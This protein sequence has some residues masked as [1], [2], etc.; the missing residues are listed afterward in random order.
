MKAKRIVLSIVLV[1]SLALGISLG[2]SCLG[3]GDGGDVAA[4]VI[5]MLKMMP[6][7]ADDFMSIDME[8]L[9]TDD[10]FEEIY[11]DFVG[12]FSNL[13]EYMGI[14]ISDISQ[15]TVSGEGEIVI[16]RGDINL[17]AVRDALEETGFEEQTYK[18]VEMWVSPGINLALMSDTIIFGGEDNV[19]DCIGV[20]E[21]GDDSLYDDADFRDVIDRLPD[22]IMV[23][24]GEGASVM[25]F[26]EY[27]GL[28][29]TG[30]SIAKHSSD[31]IELTGIAKF[32]DADAAEDAIDDL[33]QDMEGDE[34]E[35]RNID[36]SQD[37]KYLEATAEGDIEGLF[38]D[39]GN[40][41]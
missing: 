31:S 2:T 7:G 16:L 3:G 21:E 27:D 39:D 24:V 32:T 35:L 40:G 36:V 20:I 19:K 29:V 8:A 33:R 25:T 23:G 28:K 37:G 6:K 10:D 5:D 18:G 9:R 41:N 30:V 12:D 11:N 17:D 34:E 26:D 14:D 1:L 15:F 4:V 22:G 38:S 13:E